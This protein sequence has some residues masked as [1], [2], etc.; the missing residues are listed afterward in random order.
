MMNRTQPNKVIYEQRYHFLSLP[1]LNITFHTSIIVH[2]SNTDMTV[3][4]TPFLQILD[5]NPALYFQLQQQRLIE[6]IRAK[7]VDEALMFAQEEL[8]PRGEEHPE[9]L[10]DLEETMTLL[11]YD[12][13]LSAIEARHRAQSQ[14][15]AQAAAATTAAA[16]ASATT[17]SAAGAA[18]ENNDGSLPNSIASLLH[19]SHRQSTASKVNSAILIS[20]S[21]GS[22]PKLPNLLR[23]LA[24]GEELL[25]EKL[26]FPKMD[27]LVGNPSELEAQQRQAQQAK[28]EGDKIGSADVSMMI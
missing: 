7:K 28:S 6:L 18:E 26:D 17:T 20:Q 21:H 5:N 9:F 14:A 13:D 8:A 24:W 27:L 16:G 25:Y 10:S 22:T 19:P 15:Q 12:I 1:A 11:A 23:M 2:T 3:L 4:P